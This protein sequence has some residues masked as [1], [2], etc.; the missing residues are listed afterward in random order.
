MAVRSTHNNRLAPLA[1]LASFT[2]QAEETKLGNALSVAAYISDLSTLTIEQSPNKTNWYIFQQKTIEPNVQYII[3]EPCTL[4]YFRITIHNEMLTDQAYCHLVTSLVQELTQGVDIRPLSSATDGV[5]MYGK[6]QLGDFLPVAVDASGN[7]IT[8][9]G[10]GGAATD[11]NIVSA[12]PDGLN[13]IGGV[14]CLGR[15]ALNQLINLSMDVTDNLLV[16]D[17]ASQG[18]LQ[19]INL[20]STTIQEN[21]AN[22]E[23]TNAEISNYTNLMNNKITKCNTD[24]V[25]ISSGSIDVYGRQ[26]NFNFF[27]TPENNTINIYADETKGTNV[28]GGWS[29]TNTGTPSKI[30]W[31]IYQA[32]N[33]L[34]NPIT[35]SQIVGSA[36]SVYAVVNQTSVSTPEYPFVV[37]YTRA[38]SGTNAGPFKS[39]LV[40]STGATATTGIKLLYTGVDP[41]DIHPEITGANRINLPFNLGASTKPL[42]DAY[43]EEILSASLQT[44]SGALAGVYNFVMSQFGIEWLNTPFILPIQNGKVMVDTGVITS[45]ESSPTGAVTNTLGNTG[46]VVTGVKSTLQSLTISNVLGTIF[47]YVKVYNKA[48]AP[49]ASDTPVMT[50]PL[51]HDSVQQIECHSLAFPLGIGLRAT[52][53]FASGNTTAPDGT[54]YATAFY[55]NVIN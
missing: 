23:T 10:G 9:G 30:N 8:T 5:V 20:T 42:A 52:L 49:T 19:S 28:V 26:S 29:F 25:S 50:L 12:L 11:V 27:P 38:D 39:R 35:N 33:P 3:Q 15:N 4:A 14:Y 53:L 1:G 55:T 18:F 16:S 45:I 13:T 22:I 51:N 46:V 40:F 24:M 36:S 54:I 48:T 2:G 32:P 21:T 34:G 47:G 43:Y 17:T 37:I 41:V 6:D 44:D 31:Y 7:I